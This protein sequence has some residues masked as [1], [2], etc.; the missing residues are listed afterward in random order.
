VRCGCLHAPVADARP[1]RQVDKG[2][3]GTPR[4]RF[5]LWFARDAS[6]DAIHGLMSA[7]RR[8][9]EAAAGAGVVMPR[10]LHKRHG[11]PPAAA[12]AAP[13]AAAA[14]ATPLLLPGTK[15]KAP[16]PD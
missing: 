4:A 3:A 16:M 11:N 13:A 15:R 14:A 10:L 1:R 7:L 6:G 5:E 12:A 2:T 8:V 9:V